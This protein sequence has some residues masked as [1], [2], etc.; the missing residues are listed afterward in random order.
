MIISLTQSYLEITF[1][2]VVWTYDD[3]ENKF[4][5]NFEVTNY[6][7]KNC[8]LASDQHF[9]KYFLKLALVKDTAKI[10]RTFWVP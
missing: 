3:F 4:E 6:L 10:A 2:S 8:G 9:S 5:I 7:K 1:A